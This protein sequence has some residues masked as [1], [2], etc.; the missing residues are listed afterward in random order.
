MQKV[1][2]TRNNFDVASAFCRENIP[3]AVYVEASSPSSI[4]LLL[5]NIPGVTRRWGQIDTQ[6]VSLH[7]RIP[8]LTMAKV[9]PSVGLG[10][11]VRIFRKGRYLHD[12][13]LVSKF[14]EESNVCIVLAV[15]R[16]RLDRKRS[17]ENSRPMPVLFDP[18]VA[19]SMF[20][21]V[22][23]Q[24]LNT[25]P[26]SG[27]LGRW[28]YRNNV[29]AW[30]L[31]ELSLNILDL[32]VLE[33]TVPENTLDLFHRSGHDAVSNAINIMTP[34]VAIGD[35]ILVN[36]AEHVDVSGRIVEVDED[37]IITFVTDLPSSEILQVPTRNIKRFLMKGD[38]VRVCLGKHKGI[39]GYIVE[40]LAST[41]ILYVRSGLLSQD[42]GYE[43]STIQPAI[44]YT[45]TP[46]S[47]Q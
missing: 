47:F 29:Y 11:W 37:D 9:M 1:L 25:V 45:L 32:T 40:K 22:T 26:T 23:V 19:L 15:P 39:E 3:G 31:V 21:D 46:C 36:S 24:S 38:Y 28:R 35:R 42:A 13:G 20:G 14:D 16:V 8:L 30:G 33:D 43:V 27:R 7:D 2:R 12:I 4:S 10:S 18:T 34:K 6:L 41:A 44:Y 5:L 17:H